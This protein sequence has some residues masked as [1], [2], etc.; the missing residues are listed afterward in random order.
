VVHDIIFKHS[1]A[2]NKMPGNRG[3][4]TEEVSPTLLGRLSNH[5]TQPSNDQKKQNNHMSGTNSKVPTV[6]MHN[7]PVCKQVRL[8]MCTVCNRFGAA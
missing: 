8:A 1:V 3:H 7:P 4:L 6:V 2:D 5:A